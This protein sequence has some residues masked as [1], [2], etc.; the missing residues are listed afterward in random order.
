[1]SNSQTQ[2]RPG[3]PVTDLIFPLITDEIA[4]ERPQFPSEYPEE[5]LCALQVDQ[6]LSNRIL[7]LSD[8][9]LWSQIMPAVQRVYPKA[10]IRDIRDSFKKR[11]DTYREITTKLRQLHKQANQPVIEKD[12]NISFIMRPAAFPFVYTYDG[13]EYIPMLSGWCQR[14]GSDVVEL[15]SENGQSIWQV[16]EDTIS[17]FYRC[18][19]TLIQTDPRKLTQAEFDIL[20]VFELID[21]RVVLPK[22]ERDLR[23]A[24]KTPEEYRTKQ[25]NEIIMVNNLR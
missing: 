22:K 20:Y 24:L 11:M 16:A 25:M 21:R 7:S 2:E 12:I 17:K 1:M 5:F 10:T 19:V 3:Y 14:D 13:K 15:A 8:E 6:V 18:L 23:I 4:G 9:Q